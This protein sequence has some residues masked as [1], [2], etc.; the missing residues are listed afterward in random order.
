[1]STSRTERT[2]RDRLRLPRGQ[3]LRGRS[4]VA[5]VFRRSR[6]VGGRQLTLLFH[7]NG[8]DHNRVVVSARRGFHGAV[9]RNRERR[10]VKEIYRQLRPRLRVGYDIALIVMAPPLPVPIRGAEVESLMRRAGLLPG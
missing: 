9:E 5:A 2:Q 6:R 8:L 7:A 1:M 4:G 10:R 3:R